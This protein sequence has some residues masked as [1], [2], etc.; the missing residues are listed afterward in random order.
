[1][2]KIGITGSIASGKTTASEIISKKKGPLFNADK[3]VKNLYQIKSFKNKVARKLNIKLNPKFKKELKNKILKNKNDLKK[4]EKLIHPLVRKQMYKFIK[5]NKSKKYVFLEVPLLI[6]NK[7][8][9]HFDVIIFIK[10]DTKI[11]LKRFQKKGGSK[12]LFNL[13]NNHQFKDDIKA[14]FSDHIVVNNKSLPVLKKKLSNIIKF[15]E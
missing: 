3:V 11:R 4:I 5:L 14:K 1:M 12:K 15:Y 13:L 10:S 7:L 2:I 6:E 8:N 9:K